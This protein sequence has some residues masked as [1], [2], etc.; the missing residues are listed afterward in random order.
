VNYPAAGSTHTIPICA[1]VTA[2]TECRSSDISANYYTLSSDKLI[3][4][5]GYG[6]IWP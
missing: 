5:R 2:L 1:L 3:T 6:P 4:F